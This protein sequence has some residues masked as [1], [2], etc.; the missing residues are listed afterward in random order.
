MK[1]IQRFLDKI[2]VSD[3][4]CWDWQ[5]GKVIRDY[6]KFSDKGKTWRA[7]RWIYEYYNNDLNSQLVIQHKCNNTSCVNPIHLK[8]SS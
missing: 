6:G 2:E 1:A 4:G 5:A 3:S 8:Q 7:H